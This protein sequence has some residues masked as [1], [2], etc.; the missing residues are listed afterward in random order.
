MA[1]ILLLW[2][3]E[4]QGEKKGEG[5]KKRKKEKKMSF[6]QNPQWKQWSKTETDKILS[7]MGN[8]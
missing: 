2:I 3:T 1:I 8:V 7:E 6:R 4:A 5:K